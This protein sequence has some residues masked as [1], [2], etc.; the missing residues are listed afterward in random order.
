MPEKMLKEIADNADLIVRGYAFTKKNGNISV[1][2]LNS[3]KSAMYMTPLGKMLESTMDEMEQMI[4]LKIWERD[5]KYMD[6]TENW[7]A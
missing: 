4:V 7:D 1:I 2:N 3:P 5:S 6:D